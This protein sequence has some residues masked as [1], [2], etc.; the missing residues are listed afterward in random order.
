M[1]HRELGE[2]CR[3]GED[4]SIDYG[5]MYIYFIDIEEVFKEERKRRRN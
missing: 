3:H 1:T 5:F 2:A 4:D